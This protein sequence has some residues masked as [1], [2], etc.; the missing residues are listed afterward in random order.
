MRV[1]QR[2][3]DRAPQPEHIFD[4]EHEHGEDVERLEL[5]AP[6]LID[7]THRLG[8]EG[9]AV[10]D[11][12]NDEEDIDDAADGIALADLQNVVNLG[13]PATPDGREAHG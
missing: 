8:D 7:R 12:E 4:G 1:I 9:E 10:G 2:N 6:A 11:D 13:P 5:R 3:F